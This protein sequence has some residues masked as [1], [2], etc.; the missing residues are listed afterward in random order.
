[1]NRRF[2]RT[3]AALLSMMAMSAVFVAMGCQD[4]TTPA[5]TPAATATPAPKR[6]QSPH[7]MQPEDQR[8]DAHPV[9]VQSA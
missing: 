9:L 2:H 5:P 3:T 6:T 7:N 4:T 8:K 1:M